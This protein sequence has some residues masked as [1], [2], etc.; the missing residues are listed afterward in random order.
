MLC[1][2]PWMVGLLPTPCGGCTP[3][4]VNTRRLWSTRMMLEARCHKH[5]CFLTLTYDND[6]L[7]KSLSV[8]KVVHQKFMK[9]FRMGFPVPIRFLVVGEY[10]GW[11][12]EGT[13]ERRVNPHYHYA[14][15]GLDCLGPIRY[16]GYGKRC[17]CPVCEKIRKI[18]GMGNIVIEPLNPATTQYIAGYIMKKM[19]KKDDERLEGRNPEFKLSSNGGRLKSGG[20]GAPAMPYIWD[21]IHNK[22]TGEIYH[23]GDD[24]PNSIQLEGKSLPLGRYLRRKLRATHSEN[25]GTPDAVLHRYQEELL[26]MFYDDGGFEKYLTVKSYLKQKHAGS[27]AL[28]EARLTHFKKGKTL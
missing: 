28:L 14:I 9:K 20:I 24:V 11:L 16:S 27:V 15:Y 7:P 10:G 12:Y 25:P 22:E 8:S 4:L 5:S 1:K 19:T 17:F 6:N 3:C 23:V 18:W 13:G 2:N 26:A 21:A